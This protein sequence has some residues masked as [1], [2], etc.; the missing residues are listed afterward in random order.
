MRRN[1]FRI[2]ERATDNEHRRARSDQEDICLCFMPLG[3]TVGFAPRQ[4]E[5]FI[6]EISEPFRSSMIRVSIGFV[7]E[8]LMEGH[9]V[10]LFP[11]RRETC[12]DLPIQFGP[13]DF[14]PRF[15]IM[16]RGCSAGPRR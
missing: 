2:N 3:L 14:T 16:D 7:H 13:S 5:S 12:Q 11:L 4:H 10:R 1:G 9:R 15:A 8:L 6:C